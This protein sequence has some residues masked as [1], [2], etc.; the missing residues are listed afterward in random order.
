MLRFVFGVVLIVAATPSFA[1]DGMM[2]GYYGNTVVGKSAR[3][4]MH[5]QYSADHTYKTTFNGRPS[6][7]TWAINGDQV[8]LTQT[9][10]K[11]SMAIPPRCYAMA[12]HKVGDS[13]TTP[14]GMTMSLVAGQ[15]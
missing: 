7:G 15:Q 4:E 13:W 11:P 8:C 2:S 9:D 12:A 6:S 1:A 10:P 5:I 14:Q 3:G